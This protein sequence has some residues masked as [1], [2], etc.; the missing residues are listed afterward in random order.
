[1]EVDINWLAVVLAAVSS[2]VVG[3][4]WYAKGVFGSSW[5]KLVNLSDKQMKEWAPSALAIA[6]ISSLVM[7]Y[8][9]AHVSFLSNSYFGNSFMQ[10][11]LTTAFWMWLGFQALR[12][13]M[14]DAFEHRPRKLSYLNMGN[15][16]VT[17]MVMGLIIGWLG[18]S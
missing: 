2:M 17:I 1:M 13:L 18:V 4:V 11:A 5:M 15:D 10:D 14:H 16:F 3:S 7:A 8:V 6:F 9:L 12:G